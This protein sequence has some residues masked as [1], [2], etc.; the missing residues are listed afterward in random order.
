MRV[1]YEEITEEQLYEE[2]EIRN[3]V[4]LAKSEKDPNEANEEDKV[5]NNDLEEVSENIVVEK[6][7]K[8]CP[9]EV[10][11]QS[12]QPKSAVFR[13]FFFDE[14]SMSD[15][16]YSRIITKSKKPTDSITN[17]MNS[18]IE[19]VNHSIFV[20]III[21]IQV[22]NPY[23]EQIEDILDSLIDTLYTTDNNYLNNLHN[24]ISSFSEFC[25]YILALSNTTILFPMTEL[26]IAMP[27]KDIIFNEGTIGSLPCEDFVSIAQVF[28][29]LSTD[30]IIKLWECLMT[31]QNIIIYTNNE[32]DYFYIMKALSTLMF[33]LNWPFTKALIPIL[34]LLSSPTPYCFGILKSKFPNL[35][36]IT[37]KLE[38]DDIK[39][40][41]IDIDENR[42]IT[43]KV[44]L[45]KKLLY[46]NRLQFKENLDECCKIYKINNK[47]KNM[48]CEIHYSEFASQIQKIFFRETMKLI[49]NFREAIKRDTTNTIENFR[50]QLDRKSVV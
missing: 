2:Y 30:T 12:S 29:L 39:Y 42:K 41:M 37:E 26:I 50:V 49:R 22:T 28:I 31:E 6:I 24:M 44:L 19:A 15:I 7:S 40:I 27:N 32:N 38:D 9:R 43:Q 1:I 48:K 5:I 25:C 36:F 14:M 46:P 16:S 13:Q 10:L 45:T 18:M 21:C 33:P 3:T 17:M 20:P 34:D 8:E 11:S 47:I 35:D 4:I 23:T